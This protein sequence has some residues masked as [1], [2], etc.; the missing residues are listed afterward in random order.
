[1]GGHFDAVG[2]GDPALGFQA[3][4]EHLRAAIEYGRRAAEANEVVYYQLETPEGCGLVAATDRA[5]YLLNGCPYFRGQHSRALFVESLIA[6]EPG[7]PDQGGATA[8]LTSSD[9]DD[10]LTLTFALPFF[11][12]ERERGLHGE[13][14]FN[15]VGLG[16]RAATYSTDRRFPADGRAASYFEPVAK[17]LDL[18]PSRR[19][20]VQCRGRIEAASFLINSQTNARLAYA[21][22]D[23]DTLQLEIVIDVPS[24]IGGLAVGAFLSGSFW[25]VG[26]AASATGS[27]N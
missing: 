4:R 20:N 6:W 17:Q 14:H 10:D 25:L 13:H 2:F 18:P 23:C 5:G 8:R 22:L 19:C 3:T 15:L 24:L 27:A 9:V 7:A 21:L 16:Y 11:A 26:Q 1:V 12:A